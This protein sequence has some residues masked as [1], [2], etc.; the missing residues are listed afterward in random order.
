[1]SLLIVLAVVLVV[2][3]VIGTPVYRASAAQAEQVE[4]GQEAQ[5]PMRLGMF[6]ELEAA[7]DA[8]LREIRETELDWRTGKLSEQDWRVLDASLRS[9]AA[10]IL[11]ELDR[12]NETQAPA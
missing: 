7:R 5:P 11:A 8:K 9:E 3:V 4:G 1:M 2:V 12:A 6:E 10:V